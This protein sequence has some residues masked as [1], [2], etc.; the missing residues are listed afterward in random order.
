MTPADF[1]RIA[2]FLL[3]PGGWGK[4]G[5]THIRLRVSGPTNANQDCAKWIFNLNITNCAI[6]KALPRNWR[7]KERR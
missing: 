4:M 1:P 6:L 3:I 7:V 2:L 5:R